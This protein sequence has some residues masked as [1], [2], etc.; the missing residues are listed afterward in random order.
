VIGPLVRADHARSDILNAAPFDPS[1]GPLADRVGVEQQRH[2]HRR[3][4]RR[5]TMAVGRIGREERGQIHLRDRV[6]HKPRQ[7][8]LGQP[9]AQ[10]RRQQ[11]L[12]LAITRQEVLRHP[13]MVLTAPD[14]PTVS[15]TG[16]IEHGTVGFV[17]GDAIRR[18]VPAARRPSR[19]LARHVRGR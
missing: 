18:V 7:V 8:I 2:H 4:V 9:L 1:R 6:D 17:V 11:Q 16:F 3:I 19:R 12:L 14:R 15:A 10:A 5:P 13:R